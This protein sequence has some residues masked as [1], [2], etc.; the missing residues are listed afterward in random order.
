MKSHEYADL[1][2]MMS[3]SEIQ[4]F[5]DNIK[6]NG[7]ADPIILFEGKIL[8]GRNRF[9]AC[10]MVGVTPHFKD[11]EGTDPLGYVVSHNLHRRHLSESQRGM[12][13]AKLAQLQHGGDRKSDQIKSSIEPLIT[14]KQAAE[15]LNIGVNS[16]KRSKQVLKNGIIELQDMQMSGEISAAAAATVSKLPEQEQRK[17]VLGGV[18]GVKEAAKK[19]SIKEPQESPIIQE[20]R[21][22]QPIKKSRM[23]IIE[24]N[25]MAIYASAKSVMDRLSDKDTEFDQ[26]IQA[27][28]DYCEKRKNRK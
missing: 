9:R 18:S 23:V 4:P 26:S 14:Q 5:A 19:A 3:D 8:D 22:P 20:N 24:S 25:G 28:I 10:E 13:G 17:A 21:E 27:M 15:M 7:Q 12:V 11:Y 2:P 16:I 1:F 6:Q